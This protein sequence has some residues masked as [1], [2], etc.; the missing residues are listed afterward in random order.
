[1]RC[2]LFFTRSSWKKKKKHAEEHILE[3]DQRHVQEHIQEGDQRHVQEDIQEGNL[4][5]SESISKRTLSTLKNCP[6]NNF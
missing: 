1:M 2:Y 5:H 4:S 6:Q 3:G